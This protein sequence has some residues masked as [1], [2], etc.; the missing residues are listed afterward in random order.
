M[1]LIKS[2]KFH[3]DD[4]AGDLVATGE[5]AAVSVEAKAAPTSA[6]AE[7][8]TVGRTKAEEATGRWSGKNL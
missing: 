7:R 5:L 2:G 6:S 1:R 3:T 8:Q 4:V